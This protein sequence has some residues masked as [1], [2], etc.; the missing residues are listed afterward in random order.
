MSEEQKQELQQKWQNTFAEYQRTQKTYITMSAL[1]TLAQYWVENELIIENA[2]AQEVTSNGPQW[3][4]NPNDEDSMGEYYMECKMARAMHDTTM[5]PMHRQSCIVILYS[6]AERELLRLVENLE[7]AHG[8]QKLRVRL[9]SH[10][11]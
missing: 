10:E 8:P 6:T 1:H 11:N 9:K 4:P 7:K 3:N 2:A 5:I